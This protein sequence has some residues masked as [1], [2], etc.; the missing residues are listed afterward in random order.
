MAV[1]VLSLILALAQEQEEEQVMEEV[2]FFEGL[3][4]QPVTALHL[5]LVQELELLMVHYADKPVAFI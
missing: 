3:V 2:H 5:I 1:P 4:L